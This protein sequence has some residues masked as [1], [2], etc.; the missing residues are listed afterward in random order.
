[1]V[2]GESRKIQFTGRSTYVVSLPKG[3]VTDLGLSQGDQVVLVRRGA[4]ALE[5]H[6]PGDAAPARREEAVVEIG[7]DEDESAIIRKVISLY[8]VGFGSISLR[9]RSGRLSPSQRDA[10]KG[11]VRRMLMGAEITSDSSSGMT[12]QVLVGL[13]ELSIGGAFRRMVHLAKSMSGDA[14]L[15][16]AEGN[17]A[18]AE[19]VILAD[20]EVDRF[21]FYIIRQLAIAIRSE[22]V[23][24]EMG[25]KGAGDCLGYRIAVKNVERTGDHAAYIAR[26]M[27]EHGRPLRGGVLERLRE[28]NEFCLGSLDAACL[29]LFKEDHAGA[30]QI[31]SETA[32][33][34]AYEER[35]HEASGSL[36]AG[37]TYLVRRTSENIRRISE[38]ASD[39]AEI[40]LN[41]NI[42]KALKRPG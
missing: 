23:L 21:G 2:E 3:W 4:K 16:L 36:D 11:A 19:G 34:S 25:L 20:D 12:V 26:D 33:I 38:Y 30:E 39:I 8:I 24:A 15:A 14:L 41:L 40:V 28:M 35:V 5:I 29:A 13:L 18:L 22:H 42:E 7:Q 17:R 32:G 1:M 10:V 37:Q 6:P 27:L 9:P 31:I